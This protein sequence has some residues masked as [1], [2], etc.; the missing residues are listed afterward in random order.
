LCR[1]AEVGELPAE[2][3]NAADPDAMGGGGLIGITISGSEGGKK[4]KGA[5]WNETNRVVGPLYK[6]N[7]VGPIA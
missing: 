7:P 5:S 4:K 3:E 1:Y 6:L 2:M